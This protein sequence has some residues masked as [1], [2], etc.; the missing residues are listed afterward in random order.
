MIMIIHWGKWSRKTFPWKSFAFVV[1]ILFTAVHN[2]KCEA[3][4]GQDFRMADNF[5]NSY[6]QK[7]LYLGSHVAWCYQS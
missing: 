2:L 5:I 7:I 6:Q 1:V 4:T 3:M